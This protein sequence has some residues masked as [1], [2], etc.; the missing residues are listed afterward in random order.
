MGSTI[1]FD[2]FVDGAFVD[3]GTHRCICSIYTLNPL[4]RP[5]MHRIVCIMLATGPMS[6]NQLRGFI[7]RHIV[8]GHVPEWS[9]EHVPDVWMQTFDFAHRH[10]A[11]ADELSHLELQL[12]GMCSGPYATPF[13]E[14]IIDGFGGTVSLLV[15]SPVNFHATLSVIMALGDRMLADAAA[16]QESTGA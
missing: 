6:N 9:H 1:L 7:A 11:G 16:H 2:A 3:S 14:P 13:Y 15:L 10:G 5:D 4:A 8:T 12:I